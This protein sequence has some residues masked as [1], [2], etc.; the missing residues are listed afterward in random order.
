MRLLNLAPH[1]S[2]PPMDGSDRRAWHLHENMVAAGS[3][4]A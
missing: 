1:C 2:V 3:E 4:A